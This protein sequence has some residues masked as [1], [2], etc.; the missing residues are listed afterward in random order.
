MMTT[1]SGGVIILYFNYLNPISEKIFRQIKAT[2]YRN[3]GQNSGKMG[4]GKMEIADV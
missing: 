3:S 1:A 4:Y 2:Q